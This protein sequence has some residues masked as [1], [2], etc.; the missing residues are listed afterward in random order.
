MLEKLF[1][2]SPAKPEDRA[3]VLDSWLRSYEQSP[4]AMQV[5]E[6][7]YFERQRPL[8]ERLLRDCDTVIAR[9]VDW[10]DGIV[11]WA[12]GQSLPSTFVLHYANVKRDY[13]RIGLGRALVLQLGLTDSQARVFTHP[14][15]PWTN[16]LKRHGF[17]YVKEARS[18]RWQPNTNT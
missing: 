5:G 1:T 3:Y 6:R 10:P 17:Q 11:G 2:F 15:P 9:P 12:C 13:R 7:A 18:K 16:A 8:T 4:W 14:R